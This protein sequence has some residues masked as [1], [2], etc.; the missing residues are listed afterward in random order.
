MQS[1]L[2]ISL[3]FFY[4]LFELIFTPP[5]V[6]PVAIGNA[7]DL[8]KSAPFLLLHQRAIHRRHLVVR[9]TSILTGNTPGIIGTHRQKFTPG[10]VLVIGVEDQQTDCFIA[11]IGHDLTGLQE[12]VV[13]IYLTAYIVKEIAEIGTDGIMF[14]QRKV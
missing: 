9:K 12:Q 2:L 1:L 3:L 7:D 5:P 13:F 14:R 8:A 4:V 10:I 6:L 11:L